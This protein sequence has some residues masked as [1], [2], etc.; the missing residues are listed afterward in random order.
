MA[1]PLF[2]RT[3]VAVL[4]TT[5]VAALAACG[6]SSS[7][8]D[9][10][11]G[12]G[13]DTPDV[14][15]PVTISINDLPPTEEPE[16]RQSMLDKIERFEA[17]HPHIT[18]EATEYRWAA[19]TFPAMLAGGTE[20]TVTALPFTEVQ[21]LAARGQTAEIS[22]QLEG[23]GFLEDLNPG[24]MDVVT[25]PGGGVYGVP[26]AAYTAGLIYNRALFTQAGL[27]PDDPPKT[28]D[29]IRAAAK[30]IQEKT[31]VPG[32]ISMTTE[33]VGGWTLTAMSAAFGGQMEEIDGETATASFNAEPTKQALEFLRALRWEDNTMGSNFLVNWEDSR[34]EFG[35][36]RAGMFIGG[37]DAYRD[38]IDTRGLPPDDFGVAP[39][40]L[41]GDEAAALS[42]GSVD[43]ISAR[44]TPEEVDAAITWIQFNRFEKYYSEQAARESADGAFKDGR[45]VGAPE[46]PIVSQDIYDQWL[47]WIDDMINV[48]RENAEYYL[49]S[50]ED[51]PLVA[52]P[53]VKGQELYAALDPVVQA[54]LTREDADIDALL[55]EAEDNVNALIQA[56]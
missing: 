24:L 28:W 5:F 37:A 50:I 3:V 2:R 35:A 55:A 56:G 51:V 16:R 14:D 49:T 23:A 9:P 39:L 48:P 34:N 20:P 13:G 46:L 1:K 27:D 6:T 25:A 21:G 36:G 32:L 38:L 19:D 8:D 12:N 54:V 30:T 18:I 53:P 29:D 33:N 44:A 31:G 4:S 10:A 15:A 40:P 47:V 17:D 41:E 7:D 26:Y 42:G 52:E 11:S 43:V 22:E 45:A